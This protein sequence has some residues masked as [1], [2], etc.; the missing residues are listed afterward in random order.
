MWQIG[1][2]DLLNET[3]QRGVYTYKRER[4]ASRRIKGAIV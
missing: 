2:A 3:L 4:D 1:R